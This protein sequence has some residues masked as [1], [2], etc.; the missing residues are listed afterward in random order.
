MLELL[1]ALGG[2]MLVD[3]ALSGDNALVIGAAAAGLPAR[4][5]SRAILLGG[6][7]AIVLRIIF[8]IAV[9]LLLR[10]PLLQALGG[11]ALLYI[12]A[13]LLM[14]RSGRHASADEHATPASQGKAARSAT[15]DAS[16]FTRALLTI[17]VADVTMSLDNVLAIGA[18]AGGD[19]P[20]LIVGLVGSIAVVLAGSALLANLIQRL[21]WLLDVAALVLGWTAAGMALH[22]LRFGPILHAALPYAEVIV[23]ALGVSIVL[24]IDVALRLRARRGSPDQPDQPDQTEPARDNLVDTPRSA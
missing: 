24:A 20:V 10:L 23:P 11:V 3:I 19:L 22:D 17:L 18:L 12:A 7:G 5:R 13:R 9:T 2:V 1:G 16:G 14:E 4:Q 21:P 8:T 15:G 6:A